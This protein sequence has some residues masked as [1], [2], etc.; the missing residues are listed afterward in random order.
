[1]LT[2]PLQTVFGFLAVP[3]KHIFLKPRVTRVAAEKYG[4]DFQYSSRPN[5]E[6]YESLLGFAEQIRNDMKDL[7]PADMIDLQSFIWVMGSDE[8]A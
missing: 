2:W 8:Y 5:R 3:Q 4:Y 7:R 6:T 1:V